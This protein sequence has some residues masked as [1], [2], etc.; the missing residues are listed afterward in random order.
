M[1]AYLAPTPVPSFVRLMAIYLARD[2][3]KDNP[4]ITFVLQLTYLKTYIVLVLSDLK[5]EEIRK[6]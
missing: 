1:Q 2:Q 5:G 3:K 6:N 4:I